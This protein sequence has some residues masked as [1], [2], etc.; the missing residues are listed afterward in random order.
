[1]PQNSCHPED[2]MQK[3]EC[4]RLHD[5]RRQ[6]YEAVIKESVEDR[7]DIRMRLDD[8]DRKIIGRELFHSHINLI[9]ERLKPVFE[10][11]TE[12]KAMKWWMIK[13]ALVICCIVGGGMFVSYHYGNGTKTDLGQKMAIISE[14]QVKHEK[15]S[16]TNCKILKAL[17][18]KV[19][20]SVDGTCDGDK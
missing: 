10:A 6:L 16:E 12:F 19:G 13:I 9:E 14:K 4:D 20:V 1:M 15:I 17:A 8:L 3:S 11:V 18:P 2:F 5:E 7:R